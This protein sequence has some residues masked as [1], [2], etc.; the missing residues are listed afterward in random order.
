MKLNFA[1]ALGLLNTATR[2]KLTLLN[3][4]RN[5]CSH[6]WIL[7]L[8]QRRGRPPKEKKLPF[9]SYRGRD[10]HSVAV[11]KDFTA[12][13]GPICYKLFLKLHD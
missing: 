8:P 10:L 5:K 4:L 6:N 7:N 2:Q 9:L 1:I 12:D 13:Y 3:T 11:F